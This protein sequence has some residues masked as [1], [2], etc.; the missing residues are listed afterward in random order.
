MSDEKWRA[1]LTKLKARVAALKPKEQ[2]AEEKTQAAMLARMINKAN[3][4][5]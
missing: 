1:A 5:R 3:K 2:T 4:L